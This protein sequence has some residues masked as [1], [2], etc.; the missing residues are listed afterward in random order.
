M[1]R[2]FEWNSIILHKVL[3]GDQNDISLGEE[4]RAFRPRFSASPFILRACNL[5]TQLKAMKNVVDNIFDEYVEYH[6]LIGKKSSLKASDRANLDQEVALFIA[7]FVKEVHEL[8]RN[9]NTDSLNDGNP[10]VL[11]HYT[12]IISNILYYLSILNKKVHH[13]QKE[14][15]KYHR[16][17]FIL[18]SSADSNKFIIPN[19]KESSQSSSNQDI[20]SKNRMDKTSSV[21]KTSQEMNTVDTSKTSLPKS[22]AERYE[23]EIAPPSKMKEYESVAANHKAAL[24]KE[25]RQLRDKFS[26]EMQEANKMEQTV[27]GISGM[28]EEF[29]RILQLQSDSIEDVHGA[30]KAA[31][32]HVEDTSEQLLLTI[33]RSQSHQRTMV[34]LTVVLGLLLLLLDFLTP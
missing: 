10:S 17:P 20:N 28:L 16:N 7:T 8:K 19:F 11:E 25:T 2:T 13:M 22:F 9:N 15:K 12:E 34:L 5:F 32:K 6:H 4:E 31:T 26:E 30:S 18:I 3:S 1:D 27:V 21:T 29:V 24:L 33:E 23:S 14:R